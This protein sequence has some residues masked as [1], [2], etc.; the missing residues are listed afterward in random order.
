MRITDG[1]A[2]VTPPPEVHE[3][4][5]SSS[6]PKT[7]P[8]ADAGTPASSV[9]QHAFSNLGTRTNLSGF[10]L[11]DK[12]SLSVSRTNG[13]FELG[14]VT[15]LS[16]VSPEVEV[17]ATRS[18]SLK[19]KTVSPSAEESKKPEEEDG[20]EEKEPNA[21]LAR[22]NLNLVGAQGSANTSVASATF[23]NSHA[24]FSAYALGAQASGQAGLSVTHDGVALQASGNANAYLVDVKAGV[25]GGPVAAS[26]DASVGA[27]VNGNAEV[28]LNPL[29][30]DVGVNGGVG[31]FAGAQASETASLGG[32]GTT[33]SETANVGAGVGVDAKLDVGID[34]GDVGVNFDIGAYLGVGASTDVSFNVNVPKLADSAWHDITSIF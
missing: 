4:A 21:L 23:S 1:G 13:D 31:A 17:T 18:S 30:G 22:T 24:Y 16:Y 6:P 19:V 9:T 20:S 2:P 7:E 26:G 33:A 28:A 12:T 32:D 3:S 10:A 27:G 29:K 25:H 14:R 5:S 15:S 34:K 8:S 11:S